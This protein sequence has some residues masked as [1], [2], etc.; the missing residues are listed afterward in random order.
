MYVHVPWSIK[1][2]FHTWAI[3]INKI[4]TLS[5]VGSCLHRISL[6]HNVHR[7]W[8]WKAW[9]FSVLYIFTFTGDQEMW[10]RKPWNKVPL[11]IM[12]ICDKVT[13]SYI[14]LPVTYVT[15]YTTQ[16]W[17]LLTD[18]PKLRWWNWRK[19]YHLGEH[20]LIQ[21][22]QQVEWSNKLWLQYSMK[23]HYSDILYTLFIAP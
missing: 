5:V 1:H 15:V 14:D 21:E 8:T 3:V 4:W 2:L 20:W 19:S 22:I 17:L 13:C 11:S 9:Y 10:E 16:S 12:Y 23:N 18:K 6:A 7:Q